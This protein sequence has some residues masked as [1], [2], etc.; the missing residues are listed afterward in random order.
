M[1]AL[2][3]R[4]AEL[5]AYQRAQHASARALGRSVAAVEEHGLAQL[6]RMEVGLDARGAQLAALQTRLARATE[7]SRAHRLDVW[8]RKLARPEGA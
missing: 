1:Q 6:Q 5:H 7:E 4:D 3:R 2:C 8:A